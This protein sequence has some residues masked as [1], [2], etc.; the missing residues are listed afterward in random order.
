MKRSLHTLFL[1]I[2]LCVSML[3]TT[4]LPAHAEEGDNGEVKDIVEKVELYREGKPIT[5][6][7]VIQLNDRFELKYTLKAPLFLNFGDDAVEG[8][9]CYIK[10]GDKIILPKFPKILTDYVKTITMD[11]DD[12]EGGPLGVV[13]LDDDGNILLEVTSEEEGVDLSN[14]T[15]GIACKL[16]ADQIGDNEEYSIDL[17]NN[18]TPITLKIKDNQKPDEPEPH[19]EEP[20][21]EKK[22]DLTKKYKNIER[23]GTD[24]IISWEI[25]LLIFSSFKMFITNSTKITLWLLLLF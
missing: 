1:C 17:P 7:D 22:I 19:E 13:T 24:A 12:L 8:N 4:F 5:S 21:L 20:P 18:D 3:T 9:D 23:D 16:D 10:K 25:H 6:G 11:I 14:V 15:F 2:F